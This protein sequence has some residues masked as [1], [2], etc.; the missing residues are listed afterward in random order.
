M[1]N[2]LYYRSQLQY[3]NSAVNSASSPTTT[4]LRLQHQAVKVQPDTCITV[5][6]RVNQYLYDQPVTADAYARP[7]R[8]LHCPTRVSRSEGWDCGQSRQA[9]FLLRALSARNMV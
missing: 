8:L 6:L 5:T 7:W 2:L 1:V 4:L 3:Q 9:G